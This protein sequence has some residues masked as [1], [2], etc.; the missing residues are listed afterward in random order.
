M[1]FSQRVLRLDRRWIFIGIAL[2]VAIPIITRMTLPLG[3]VAPPTVAVY[4]F[5]EDLKPGDVVM[6]AFDY[7][8]SSMPELHPQAIALVRHCLSR[9][10][11][12]ITVSLNQ[13]GT[14]LA[15]DVLAQVG[16]ELGAVDGTDYVNL[17]FKV[18]VAA[19]ILGLG[20][21]IRKVYAQ[22]ADGKLTADLPVM[23]GVNSYRNVALLVDLAAGD[24]PQAWIA[25]A[26]ERYNQD[27]AL[28]I[29]AVMATGLYPYL[30]SG[31][32]VGLING[33]KGAAEY[34]ELTHFE[35]KGET[36]MAAQSIAH[37]LII[38]MVVLGNIAYFASGRGGR[39]RR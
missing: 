22:T 7:G 15:R 39:R 29:T 36:G 12:V 32:I 16:G 10:L 4:K 37:L 13:Q 11:R 31:Q 18:G 8:P 26:H 5:I 2:A 33:L 24:L 25:F 35:G 9:K 34:E 6:I 17:G 27:I 38:V 28:G 3:K 23:K 1:R 20:E 30:Q 19:T 21:S 14:Q